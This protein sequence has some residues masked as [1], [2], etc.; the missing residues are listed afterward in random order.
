MCKHSYY[1]IRAGKCPFAQI[2]NGK[3][4]CSNEQCEDSFKYKKNEKSNQ[5]RSIC[6][7][8]IDRSGP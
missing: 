8:D 5:Q 6:N 3:I 2:Q 4:Y 7:T 1:D